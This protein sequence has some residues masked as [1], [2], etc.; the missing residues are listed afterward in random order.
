MVNLVIVSHSAQLGEGVGALARQMLMGDGCKLAIAAGIDDPENPI[1]TDP[2]KVM[3]AIESVADTDHVLVMMD[4]G[5]ALLSAETTLELLDPDIAA[6]VRLCA[7]PLVEGTLAATVSAAAGADIDQVI[8]DAMHALDA[9]CEQLG[10][11]SPSAAKS[12]SAEPSPDTDAR[13]IAIVVK[14]PNGIHVRPASRLVS[15]LSG[16]NADMWLEKN[17]K[18]VVPDSLNQIALLQVRCN[19]TLRLIAKGEQAEDA[20]AAFKQLAA[21]NFGES[22][23]PTQAKNVATQVPSRVTGTV[24]CYTP[25]SPEISPQPAASLQAEQ[26]RLQAAIQSTLNDLSELTAL[27]EE[28][29][30]ADI[31]A[32][33]SGHHTLLDDP[34]LFD[35]ACDVMREKQCSAACAW[36]QVLSELSQQY[37]QLDDPYLQA[38]Y[39]D[40]EDLLSRSLQHLTGATAQIPTFSRP[41]I[42]VADVIY[43][44]T[45]LQLDPLTIK[46]IGLRAGSEASHPAIIAREM[47][48]CWM[49]QLGETLDSIKTGDTVTI[50]CVAHR[51]TH[52]G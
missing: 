23:A 49:C 26:Q 15:T 20:L 50:D 38:R 32:I 9:K 10:L 16:F 44:S 31:A 46:G 35:M 28:K 36:Q 2:I 17:G 37:L 25:F 45:V 1:G 19:D 22:L 33:F 7:A 40:I 43:P 12:A 51:I 14:N 8:R 27:A 29:Y 5:S 30:S 34:E 13:S 4:I 39:I 42:L 48:L 6:K 3:E 11:P 24:F 52:T 21:E 18:C 41:T 47:G